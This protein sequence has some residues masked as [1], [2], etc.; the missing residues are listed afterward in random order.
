M[1]HSLR[2]AYVALLLIVPVAI[3]KPTRP[4]PAKKEASKVSPRQQ[5]LDRLKLL[6][7]RETNWGTMD[8]GNPSF[9]LTGHPTWDAFA[10]VREDGR[11]NVTWTLKS[12]GEV[13]PGLYAVEPDGSL[14]GIWG[15]SSEVQI[16]DGELVGTVRQDRIHLLP[17][18]EPDF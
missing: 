1:L 10:T 9:E 18:P 4:A 16:V 6:N 12:N 5:S 7:G 17:T 11:I 15:P 3:A 2:V 8:L 14:N 13:C